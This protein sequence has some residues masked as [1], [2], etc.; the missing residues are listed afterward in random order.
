MYQNIQERSHGVWGN[1]LY[2]DD[3]LLTLDFI[4]TIPAGAYIAT[5]EWKLS[6]QDHILILIRLN[7]IVLVRYGIFL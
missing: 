4:G 7:L 1:V 5:Y 3:P 2:I 6:I